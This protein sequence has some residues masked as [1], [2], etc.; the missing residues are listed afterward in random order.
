V[1]DHLLAANGTGRA[2]APAARATFMRIWCFIATTTMERKDPAIKS[3]TKGTDAL[4]TKN[5]LRDML[6]EI[7]LRQLPQIGQTTSLRRCLPKEKV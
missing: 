2:T 5:S 4:L 1:D 3:C 6:D 7:T